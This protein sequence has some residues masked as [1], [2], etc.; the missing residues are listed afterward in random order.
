MSSPHLGCIGGI[1][2][3][4][5]P[6]IKPYPWMRPAALER[7]VPVPLPRVWW[8]EQCGRHVGFSAQEVCAACGEEEE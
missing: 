5:P 1:Q 2:M 8:C 4:R 7:P 3:S 6:A